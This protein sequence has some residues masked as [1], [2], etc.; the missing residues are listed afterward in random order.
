MTATTAE[1]ASFRLEDFFDGACRAWGIFQDRFG[2]LRQ[3]FVVDV[4]GEWDSQARTLKLVEDFTYAGGK[5][6][7][8]VWHLTKVGADHYEGR[9]EGI[10]GTADIRAIGNAVHLRYRMQVPIGARS[11]TLSFDDWMFRQDDDVVINRADVR[12]WGIL[13]GTATICFS[14]AAATQPARTAASQ[15]AVAS[16]S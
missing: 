16:G 12:K 15:R 1:S 14:R 9:T 4:T 7:Q 3:Q 2:K 13:I 6:E 5:T 8:R 10:V 11:W